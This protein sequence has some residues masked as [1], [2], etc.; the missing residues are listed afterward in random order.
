MDGM[1]SQVGFYGLSLFPGNSRHKG[2]V[3]TMD[4]VAFKGL[5]QNFVGFIILGNDD[6][7]AGIFIQSVDQAWPF[8]SADVA[9][10]FDVKK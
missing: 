10:I 4:L 5:R 2:P 8:N 6:N 3:N 7:A 1:T 9:E